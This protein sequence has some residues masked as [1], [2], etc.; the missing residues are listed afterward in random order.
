MGRKVRCY[1]DVENPAEFLEAA[2]EYLIS[3]DEY[4]VE[5]DSRPE[6]LIIE[7]GNTAWTIIGSHQWDKTSRT[8]IASKRTEAD[9]YSVEFLYD[10]SW[11]AIHFRP[12]REIRKEIDALLKNINRQEVEYALDYDTQV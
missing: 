11:F 10:V 8:L 12:Q 3:E 7:K 4:Q 9:G 5:R 1:F 6:A 2:G